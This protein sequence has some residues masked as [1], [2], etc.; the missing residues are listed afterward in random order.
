MNLEWKCNKEGFLREE[1]ING[2]K[3]GK[4]KRKKG[5]E[6]GKLLVIKEGTD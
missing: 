1:G 4:M 6:E 5:T 3:E 2:G